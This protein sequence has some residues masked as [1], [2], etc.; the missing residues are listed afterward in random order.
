MRLMI[1]RHNALGVGIDVGWR[2]TDLDGNPHEVWW[3]NT[4]DVT[5]LR[6]LIADAERR[7]PGF[8]LDSSVSDLLTA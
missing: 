6:S 5:S 3:G 7:L 4:R 2:I 8:A 1:A